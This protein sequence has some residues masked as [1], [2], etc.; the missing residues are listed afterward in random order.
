[1]FSKYI[2]QNISTQ[3]I[4]NIKI[5]EKCIYIFKTSQHSL[6]ILRKNTK[7]YEGDLKPLF[8]LKNTYF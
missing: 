4:S 6:Q 1:M 2:D 7:K 5:Y 3:N 8:F